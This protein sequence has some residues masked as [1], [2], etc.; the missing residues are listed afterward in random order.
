MLRAAYF[1]TTMASYSRLEDDVTCPSE[2][3]TYGGVDLV[4]CDLNALPIILPGH[5]SPLLA[6]RKVRTAR[7]LLASLDEATIN[8]ITGRS[9]RKQNNAPM[10]CSRTRVINGIPHGVRHIGLGI[11]P[12]RHKQRTD[13]L[14]DGAEQYH[15]NLRTCAEALDEWRIVNAAVKASND[16]RDGAILVRVESGDRR[17][18]VSSRCCHLH[19]ER[20]RS[21]RFHADDAAMP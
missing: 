3:G 5:F 17:F 16:H 4:T 18:Q 12:R 7:K 19:R 21:P 2:F 8:I 13:A 15:S 14:A 6:L 1:N 9:W 10:W 20:H 11:G